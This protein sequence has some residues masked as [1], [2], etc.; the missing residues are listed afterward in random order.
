MTITLLLLPYRM[1]AVSSTTAGTKKKQRHKFRKCLGVDAKDK[2]VP[3]AQ[4]QVLRNEKVSDKRSLRRMEDWNS[5]CRE[6][7]RVSHGYAEG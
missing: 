6:H 2:G 4:H 5:H 7:R 3:V 1:P